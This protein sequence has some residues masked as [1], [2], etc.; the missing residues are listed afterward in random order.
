MLSPGHVLVT[1]ANGIIEEIVSETDAG[2]E[3]EELEGILSPGFVNAHCHIELSH[4]KGVIPAQTGLVEF[5][6]QIILKREAIIPGSSPEEQFEKLLDLKHQAMSQAVEELWNSGTVA[7]GDICNTADSIE[8]KAHSNLYWHNFI[9]VS[10]FV[11]AVAQKRLSAAEVIHD[12]FT[13]RHPQYGNT[14]SPH[15]PYSVSRT[16]FNLLNQKTGGDVLSIHNQEAL[17]END[18]YLHKTGAF[19]KLY[20]DL[21]IIIDSFEPTGKSSMQSWLPYFDQQ[22]KIISVHNT[23]MN[24][25]DL[26]SF[27]GNSTLE[28]LFFC[29]C[30]NA[31]L[32]IENK[33]PPIE[34]LVNNNC[35]IVMGTDSYASNLQLN[36]LHEIKTVHAHFPQY[37]P[38]MILQWATLNGAEALGIDEQFG[39]FGKGKKPGLVLIMND[40]SSSE[41]LL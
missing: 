37:E 2:D 25:Q 28:N 41:M 31:N 3:V 4:M 18:L 21:G 1:S 12:S 26:H 15:S 27:N 22:Q 32:Y 16:L 9:E 5:V 36:M 17:A 7:I 14:I 6:R 20:E 24:E 10:G 33:L 29:V 8:L 13:I 30:I 39:S 40:L 23:F 34:L 11:D 19:L 38:A 35:K